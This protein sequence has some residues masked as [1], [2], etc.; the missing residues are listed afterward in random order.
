MTWGL[1]CQE[2]WWS[3]KSR[4]I[5]PEQLHRGDDGCD[6]LWQK[7]GAEDSLGRPEFQDLK[8]P[9]LSTHV[10]ADLGLAWVGSF[11]RVS[12]G[13]ENWAT[14]RSI[15]VLYLVVWWMHFWLRCILIFEK[16]MT[17]K[18]SCIDS[19]SQYAFNLFKGAINITVRSIQWGREDVCRSRAG[20]ACQPR[21]R[22]PG[23]EGSHF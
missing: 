9:R 1:C 13:L 18:Y 16:M 22:G 15:S 6:F 20:C 7:V 21:A 14:T 12:P 17:Y 10:E 4:I 5:C 8:S 11:E 19:C 2:L 23:I 3:C